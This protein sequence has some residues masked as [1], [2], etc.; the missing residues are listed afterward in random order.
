[1]KKIYIGLLLLS[2]V[3]AM[4]QVKI[5]R[6]KAPKPAPA[7]K[8]QIADPASF[9]LANGL[10][11]FVVQNTKL[12][13]VSATLTIDRE[14]FVEGDKSG[15]TSLAGSLLTR[16]TQAKSKA[17][18]DEAIDFL[19]AS[20][21][22]SSTSLSVSSLK[23]NFSQV[24]EL[25]AEV[26]FNP[27]FSADEL[28]KVRKQML[29]GL[30]Q[31]K[32][33]PNSISTNVVNRLVYGKDHPYGDIETEATL[34]AVTLK[35]IK[36]YFNTYWKPNIAYLVFVGD[37]TP[38]EAKSLAD[39]YFSNW[40]KGT[41]PTKTYTQP[42]APAK[43]YIAVVDRPASVQSVI[44]LVTPIELKPGSA[45]AIPS[46]V[47][48]ELL[49]SSAGRLFA[50]LREK[51]GF[52]YGAY[53]STRADKMI[54]L[55]NANA[56][57][58]TEKTDS[59]VGQF[60]YE[61]NRLRTESIPAEEV[62]RFK[63]SLSG[64]FARSL[65][66]P[67]T[68]ANFALNIARYN[69]PKDY[70]RNYLTNLSKVTP[71]DV[72]RMANT[73]VQPGNLHIIIV[74]NAKGITG[75][76][77]YGEV[78]Y[79][80][81]YGNE[82]AK[83]TEKKID[84]SVTVESVIQKAIDAVGGEKKIRAIKD[85][86]LSGTASV[87]GNE[88]N[89]TQKVIVGSGYLGLIEVQGMVLQKE[90]LRN[91]EYSKTQQGAAQPI[92]E[93]AKE[94]LNEK[95]AFFTDLYMRDKGYTFTLKGIESVDGKDAYVV[96]VKS[97]AGRV[98]TNYYDIVKGWKVKTSM[99]RETPAGNTTIQIFIRDYDERSDVKIPVKLA[100]DLGRFTQE[101]NLKDVKVNTGLT[102]D[103]LK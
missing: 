71:A 100:Y 88:L 99:V 40:K 61:F 25:M 102:A 70:Y 65:E 101:I 89:V 51:Y 84:P 55:F 23:K 21:S 59:A 27:A 42:K 49:G 9:T 43:T 75:L 37:I 76:E 22:G 103:D 39:K 35:D 16:G 19:G 18:L 66:Q 41:V 45:N 91:G 96:D 31:A 47:M 64:G 13:R 97:P 20:L 69:L 12:P 33:N 57:V 60:L 38:A 26:T 92:D 44:K 95:A 77:K 81:I 62:A 52:T 53:S 28:E 56:S 98:V 29:T 78:K 58:R 73:Y 1:M 72:Q 2:P 82:V 15:L 79:F 36:D 3:L 14:P 11:V 67:A 5:D 85:I 46:S 68:I 24:M 48:N 80:D 32:D 90:Q 74:G 86:S 54:G 63:N 30:Q 4:A 83:P 50:N 8:I 93:K 17:E 6:K 34:K 87:A 94:D 7:P 10:K